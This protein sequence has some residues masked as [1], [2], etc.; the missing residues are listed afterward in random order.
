[1]TNERGR[2]L[3]IVLYVKSPFNYLTNKCCSFEWLCASDIRFCAATGNQ[4]SSHSVCMR[5]RSIHVHGF[6]TPNRPTC[7]M[8]TYI[9]AAE[10]LISS[11]RAFLQCPAKLYLH[12]QILTL[13]PLL[14]VCVCVCV[15]F[16]CHRKRVVGMR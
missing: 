4:F 16:A 15:L 10:Y 14:S 5:E 3:I 7:M 13:S 8:C 9:Y 6:F 1:M 12:T 11:Q 2:A